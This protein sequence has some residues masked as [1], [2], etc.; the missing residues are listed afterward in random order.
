MWSELPRDKSLRIVRPNAPS[1]GSPDEAELELSDDLQ[2]MA[3]QLR[4]DAARLSE[5]Y[6]APAFDPAAVRA[7]DTDADDARPQRRGLLVGGM[8][9]VATLVVTSPY[10]MAAWRAVAGRTEQ[11]AHVVVP[12]SSISGPG[13]HFGRSSLESPPQA[14]AF[15][16]TATVGGTIVTFDRLSTS[17]QE[18]VLDLLEQQP[19]HKTGLSF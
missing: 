4:D 14:A 8:T 9:I 15:V 3:Q 19:D 10:W 2:I 7:T 1:D 11:P 13:A 17:E 12:V 6:P 16:P 18:A 5:R